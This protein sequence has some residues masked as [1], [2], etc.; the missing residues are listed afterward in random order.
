M[1]I[2]HETKNKFYIGVNEE[3]PAGQLT[4]H[5]DEDKL[6]IDHVY[7]AKALRNK[8]LGEK[9]VEKAVNYGRAN[10]YTLVP[11]CSYARMVLSETK[12]YWDVY[13]GD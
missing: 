4:F 6:I 10:N 11:Y 8:G 7:I 1:E 9:L 12:S 3:E 13:K 5:I 2:I